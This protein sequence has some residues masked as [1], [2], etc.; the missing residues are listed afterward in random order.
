VF[1]TMNGCWKYVYWTICRQVPI[2]QVPSPFEITINNY[3]VEDK[4]NI[5]SDEAK[6]VK[7]VLDIT[8]T[9]EQAQEI[10]SIIYRI[11]WRC[12]V[13]NSRTQQKILKKIRYSFEESIVNSIKKIR[14]DLP[15][16]LEFLRLLD[17]LA[18]EVDKVEENGVT[19]D[20]IRLKDLLK[21]DEVVNGDTILINLDINSGAYRPTSRSS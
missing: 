5:D 7:D 17:K 1:M 19:K 21:Y 14:R 8:F 2:E 16:F 4:K 10:E 11:M 12:N 20:V 15:T 9:A 13:E 6:V 18:V 3:F